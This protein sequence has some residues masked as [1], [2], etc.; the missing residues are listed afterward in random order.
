M[1]E[2]P[3]IDV[4]V[5]GGGL[6]IAAMA[7][8]HVFFWPLVVEYVMFV[9]EIVAMAV[10][11]YRWE[12]AQRLPWELAAAVAAWGSMAI[13]DGLLSFMLTSGEWPE[14]RS[15]VDAFFNPTYLP[16][17]AHRAM[18]SIAVTGIGG[19]VFAS[20]LPVLVGTVEERE[21]LA[22]YLAEVQR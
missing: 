22:E 13:I 7:T 15:L 6:L 4:P 1:M 11:H 17:L 10:I 12:Q 18:G 20:F 21:A 2:Y 16:S 14:T 19:L 8:L 5:I 9:V 3:Q